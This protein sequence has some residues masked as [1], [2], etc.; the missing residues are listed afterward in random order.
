MLDSYLGYFGK[1]SLI[2]SVEFVSLIIFPAG[3]KD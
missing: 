2:D 1:K 3:G